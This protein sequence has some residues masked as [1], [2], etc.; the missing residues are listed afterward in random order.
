MGWE[1]PKMCNLTRGNVFWCILA[2][3]K[4]THC[5]KPKCKAEANSLQRSTDI[6]FVTSATSEWFL[7]SLEENRKIS[8]QHRQVSEW[9]KVSELKP[10]TETSYTEECR[11]STS[12]LKDRSK[13]RK[14]WR[15]CPN[16]CWW[17][18]ILYIF[19]VLFLQSVV[20]T[21]GRHRATLSI[22]LELCLCPATENR[23][24]IPISF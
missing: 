20:Y 17:V 14:N 22:H 23:S 4:W 3:K 8:S 18:K 11:L 16:Q 2:T 7:R 9:L 21:S 15:N 5:C 13:T 12:D 19:F 6:V 10:G 1:K 24:I